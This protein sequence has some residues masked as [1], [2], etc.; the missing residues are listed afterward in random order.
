MPMPH[1]IQQQVI[2]RR[3]QGKQGAA[4]VRE[5]RAALAELPGYRNGPYADLRKWV[6]AQIAETQSRDRTVHRDTITVRRQG[7]AQIAVVG[8]PNAGKSTLL[9]ALSHVQIKTG[10]YAFTTTRPV[11]AVI[12]AG[13]VH[14][15]LVEIPGLVDGATEDRGGGRALLG[16]VRNADAIVLCH[17]SESPAHVLRRLADDLQI[18]GIEL[19]TL[20]AITKADEGDAGETRQ[21]VA[22]ALARDVPVVAV[23]VLDDGSL[24]RFRD[25]VWELTG[26][27]R[28]FLRKDGVVDREPIALVPPVTVAD[29]AAKIHGE[30][31]ARC[32]GAR[33]WGAGAS[34]QG[35]QV[36]RAHIVCDGEI[37]EII[38]S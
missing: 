11:P 18:V 10:D 28:V 3:I 36:G 26:L 27:S 19:P 34:F 29:V 31:A 25:A 5:L 8:A 37:V 12:R 24:E 23:S 1:R 9:Q 32:Q 22:A 13:G 14:V 16:V 4:R 7:A 20:V 2:R 33:L 35:Q 21:A 38:D 30:L 6:Q 17:A 15:Q